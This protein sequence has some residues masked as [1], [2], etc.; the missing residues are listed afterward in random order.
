MRY[1]VEAT[2]LPFCCYR[3]FQAEELSEASRQAARARLG[4]AQGAIIFATFGYV[5][6]VKGFEEC[7]GAVK[8]LR[9]W[10]VPAELHFVGWGMS[11]LKVMGE[12]VE[13]LGVADAVRLPGQWVSDRTYRDYLIAADY[14]I[15]L[16]SFGFG[17]LSGAVLDCISA[18]LPTICNEDLATA[19]DGPEYVLRVPDQYTAMEVAEKGRE[20]VVAG[21]HA[22]RCSPARDDYLRSHNFAEYARQM[23]QALRLAA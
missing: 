3:H 15:Q 19:M 8:H 22:V 7:L 18:G 14:A 13:R 4:L 21:L 20:A 1:G 12:M 5:H 23:M 11:L 10:G 2:Y 9:A 6:A 16:R 17:G